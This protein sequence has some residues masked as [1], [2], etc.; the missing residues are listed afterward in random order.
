MKKHNLVKVI[1]ITFLVIILLS[2]FVKSSTLNGSNV[3][4]SDVN[5]I[6]IIGF[7]QI[8]YSSILSNLDVLV[9][10]VMV[11]IMYGVLNKTNAYQQLVT[12]ISDK[13]KNKEKW[14]LFISMLLFT[15]VASIFGLQLEL[16]IFVPLFSAILM[17]TGYDNKT[18]FSATIGSILVGLLA[19]T[20]NSTIIGSINA[21]YGFDYTYQIV[22]K[23]F[24]LI[25]TLFLF[26]MHVLKK[27]QLES[28]DIEYLDIPNYEEPSSNKRKIL[29]VIIYIFVL[30]ILTV[31]GVFKLGDIAGIEIFT[32]IKEGL[33]SITL[34]KNILGDIPVFST[35]GYIDLAYMLFISSLLI[36]FIYSI[37]LDDMIDG[38]YRGAKRVLPAALILLVVSTIPEITS[39]YS[40]HITIAGKVLSY[41]EHFNI[42]ISSIATFIIAVFVPDISMGAVNLLPLVNATMTSDINAFSLIIQTIYGLV[43]LVAPTSAMLMFGL[44]YYKISY[45][46]WFK[47][48][49]RLFLYV[50]IVLMAIFIIVV[51]M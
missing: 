46:E 17:K 14:I 34:V 49:F 12:C 25:L 42:F 22:F 36:G 5:S 8:F 37:K 26:V 51:L 33:M 38:M 39:T 45:T 50:F 29:P 47:Y 40:F 18:V 9:L 10:V 7:A 31:L 21:Y 28:L 30:L 27:A 3:V 11:G 4:T 44:S 19:S 23:A 35:L 20:F 2:C 15:L 48:I 1:F 6:G 43:M 24:I 13:F 41:F 16:F 32:N